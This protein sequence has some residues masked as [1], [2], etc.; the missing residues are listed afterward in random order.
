MRAIAVAVVVVLIS[1]S[2]CLAQSGQTAER[3][4]ARAA[5]PSQAPPQTSNWTGLQA[6]AN[7]GNSSL[8][9]NFAEPG[10]FL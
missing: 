3:R 7:G 10:A 2:A 9:Q 5:G 6:G 1:A 8:A 4:K